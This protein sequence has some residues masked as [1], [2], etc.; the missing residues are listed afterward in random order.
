MDEKKYDII[1]LIALLQ[2]AHFLNLWN[3]ALKNQHLPRIQLP[4][5]ISINI[6]Q[7]L[8][9][10]QQD[11]KE[12]IFFQAAFTEEEQSFIYYFLNNRLPLTVPKRVHS[13]LEGELESP[14]KLG[15]PGAELIGVIVKKLLALQQQ[16][17]TQ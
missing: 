3:L 16:E 4:F 2:A 7:Q 11:C 17:A 13:L 8:K 9:H 5:A 15:T 12:K 1:H 14:V 10:I 6:Q